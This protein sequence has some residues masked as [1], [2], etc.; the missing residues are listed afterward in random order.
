MHFPVFVPPLLAAT[1]C[2]VCALAG[3]NYPQLFFQEWQP[4][5]LYNAVQL[6]LCSLVAVAIANTVAARKVPSLAATV[7]WSIV[8]GFCAYIGFDELFQFHESTAPLAQALRDFLGQPGNRPVIAG[9]ELPSYS[10]L[11]E[12][13]YAVIAAGVAIAFRQ[14]LLLQPTARCLIALSVLFLCGSQI[15]DVVLLQ[16]PSTYLTALP[17]D[18]VVSDGLLAALSQSLKVAGFATVLAALLETLLAKKQI[19]SVERMLSE[20]NTE[21][22]VRVIPSAKS[23]V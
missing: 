6:F 4:A 19:L 11:I 17:G 9:F 2:L 22:P 21:E 5:T 14:N 1:M 13:S 12:G 23:L 8:G 18:L 3:G 7:L 16:G 20:F 15:V 10:F